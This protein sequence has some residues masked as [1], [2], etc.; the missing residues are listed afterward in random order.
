MQHEACHIF[1]AIKQE[2]VLNK[3]KQADVLL[4]LE[5]FSRKNL[6]AR[7]SFSTKITDYFSAGKCIFAV[8]NKDL[9][10]IE[11]FQQ[12]NSAFVVTK[13]QELYGALE[14]VVDDNLLSQCAQYAVACGLKNHSKEK[15]QKLFKQTVNKLYLEKRNENITN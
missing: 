10:S 4:F 6:T 12:T 8:G 3:Q 15:T 5:D 7:L 9:S 11:Y 14:K 2:E 1:P 13:I